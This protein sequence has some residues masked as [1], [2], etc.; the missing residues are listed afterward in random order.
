MPAPPTDGTD[1][2][3]KAWAE[4]R[5]RFLAACKPPANVRESAADRAAREDRA[6]AAMRAVLIG[7]LDDLRRVDR[8]YEISFEKTKLGFSVAVAQH[9]NRP[10]VRVATAKPVSEGDPAP[11]AGDELLGI[12]DDLILEPS[13]ANLA[14]IRGAI[15]SLPRPLRL[16]FVRGP[17]WR[18]KTPP[19]GDLLGASV[20]IK[21]TTMPGLEGLVCTVAARDDAPGRYRLR[22]PDGSVY[23]VRRSKFERLPEEP[24]IIRRSSS[25]MSERRDSD[26]SFSRPSLGKRRSSS[27]APVGPEP[28]SFEPVWKSREQSRVDGVGRPKFDFYTGSKSRASRRCRRSRTPRVRRGRRPR[29]LCRRTRPG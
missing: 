1:P 5:K 13:E 3:A 10:Y 19:N 28:P 7:H 21:G 16:L 8:A 22:A 6:H 29:P 11:R 23:A 18:P 15:S 4:S 14:A 20:V 2:L 24:P 25:S 17:G 9:P 27:L 26:I 12:G